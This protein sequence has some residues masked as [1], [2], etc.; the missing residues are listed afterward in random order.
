MVIKRLEDIE[1]EK[2]EEKREK[3]VG[4]INHVIE[5]V[6]NKPKKD[7]K[8]PIWLLVKI[9]LA[10]VLLITLVNIVLGNVW[11]LKFFWNELF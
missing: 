4:D 8:G 5:G 11:L 9:A 10:S 6:F 2:H 1:R 3:L 7:N